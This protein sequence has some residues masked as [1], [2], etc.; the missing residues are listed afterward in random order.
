[1]G[2][3]FPPV[4]AYPVQHLPIVQAYAAKIGLVE[5]IKQIVPTEMAID[6][7]TIVLGMIL[8]TLSGRSPLYRLEEGV[9]PLGMP[10]VLDRVMAPAITQVMTPRFDPPCRAHSSGDR[11]SG[12][13][14][15]N[16]GGLM[17]RLARRRADRRVRRLLGR[18]WRAGDIRPDGRREPTP[19][20]GPPGVPLAPLLA[21]G[22]A[23]RSGES[24]GA[25]RPARARYAADVRSCVRSQ[26]TAARR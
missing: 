20:G 11:H 21:K 5:V 24:V 23:R 17:H 9:A 2:L 10:P 25:A 3:V 14:T 15:V 12:F 16:P 22:E 4:E 18:A 1:M 26:R 13:D 19:C 7:G 8:D 6:P